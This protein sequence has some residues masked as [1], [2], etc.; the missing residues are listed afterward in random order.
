MKHSLSE[1]LNEYTFADDLQIHIEL[2][3][4]YLLKTFVNYFISNYS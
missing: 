3:F 2:D 1:S 4:N